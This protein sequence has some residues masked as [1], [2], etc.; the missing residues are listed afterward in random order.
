MKITSLYIESQN[1]FEN[2]HLDLTYPA[3]HPKAGQPLSK[4]CLIGQSGTGKT[5]LLRLFAF[6]T[7]IW[8]E[9]KGKRQDLIISRKNAVWNNAGLKVGLDLKGK[10]TSTR[11]FWSEQGDPDYETNISTEDIDYIASLPIKHVLIPADVIHKYHEQGSDSNPRQL[12]EEF[13]NFDDISLQ[14]LWQF[15]LKDYQQYQEEEIKQRL[16]IS[17]LAQ[18]SIK[19][20]QIIEAVKNLEQ[21]LSTTPNPIKDLAENGLDKILNRFEL[22]VKQTLGFNSKEDIGF[23]KIETLQGQ[24]VKDGLLSTGTK[25]VILT[26]LPLHA[27]KPKQAVVLFDEPER[28]LYPDIQ[29][30]I[31]D[32]YTGLAPD[33]QFFFATHSPLVAASFEPWEIVELKFDRKTSKVY[34]ELY[35]RGKRH[36]DNYFINPQYLRWD[37]VLTRIFDLNQE[38]HPL[39]VRALMK[40]AE[41]RALLENN[42]L[43]VTEK[44]ALSKDYKKL[45]EQLNWDIN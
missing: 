9:K 32:F 39:R 37:A 21:W 11:Y 35:Y 14:D 25:Q 36:I 29:T 40:L 24:E 12:Q 15:Y 7:S 23:V 43:S 41:Q 1:Q 5:T 26:A 38:G 16:L 45:A 13:I 44:E 34:Q 8:I 4:V 27:L 6:L 33:C 17:E 31:V 20:A 19:S 42:G 30:E 3:G 28:S 18:Q 10:N 22:R 2:F